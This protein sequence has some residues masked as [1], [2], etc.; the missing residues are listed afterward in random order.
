MGEAVEPVAE[1]AA[2]GE[3]VAA[4]G[5]EGEAAVEVVAERHHKFGRR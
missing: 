3:A 5:V 4:V 2:P 1:A